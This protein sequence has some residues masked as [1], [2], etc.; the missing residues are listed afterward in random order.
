[1]KNHFFKDSVN[2]IYAIVAV[3]IFF[4]TSNLNAQF[5]ASGGNAQRSGY[6]K[7]KAPLTEPGIYWERSLGVRGESDPQPIIDEQGN[8]YVAGS[9]I[10][11]KKWK[12][13]KETPKGAFV[14]FDAAGNERW[15]YEWS[16]E[17]EK[18]KYTWSQ[19]TGPVLAKDSLVLL[20]SRFGQLRCFNRFTG[21]LK[22][23]C[24]LANN[25]EPVTSIPV[26]DKEGYIYIHVRD[27]PT[28]R[29]MNAET[30]EYI[31]IHRFVDNTIGNTSSPSLS[32]DEKTL[33]IGRTAKS[34]GYLYAM[35][36][37]DGTFKW[38]WSP[39][40]AH[41]HSFA[42]SI[43][44]VDD[45]GNIYIQDETMAYFYAVKDLG[46]I[47]NIQWTYKHKGDSNPRVAATNN[48]AVFSH[49]EN[50]A[51][52]LVVFALDKDGKE[53]WTQIL[54]E[55]T[56]I[57]GFVATDDAVYFGLNGTGKIMALDA[58]TGK[59]LW[60]KQVGKPNGNFSEGI[61]IGKNGVIYT[62][63]DGTKKDPDHA[64]VVALK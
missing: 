40:E 11:Y 39:E 18:N 3:L 1:M 5:S 6:V 44:V 28:L 41:G 29:K 58:S 48:K 63:V 36:T 45:N 14:S 33:Y 46:R 17:A 42:W 2:G 21:E 9:P 37:V 51:G 60:A 7:A 19:L 22:W 59:I 27:I 12:Y 32:Y 26:V 43:P 10:N 53:L 61:T 20:A 38:A 56:D 64:Y 30:G 23:E 15:R 31:W 52:K 25:G 62:G 13:K 47:H 34:V 55:G 54:N 49:Y 35:N 50:E 57:G 8:I 16:W 4:S 24:Q